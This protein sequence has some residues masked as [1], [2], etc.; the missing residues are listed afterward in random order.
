M[1]IALIYLSLNNKNQIA[2]P[3]LNYSS[4]KCYR[5]LEIGEIAKMAPEAGWD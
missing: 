3:P 5:D 4:K 2:I 1:I